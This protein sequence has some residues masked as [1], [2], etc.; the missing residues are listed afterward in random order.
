[1][2]LF[3]S[4]VIFSIKFPEETLEEIE[5]EYG[6]AEVD[7]RSIEEL[8]QRISE[9][10]VYTP[11]PEARKKIKWFI[12]YAVMVCIDFEINT[13]VRKSAHQISVSMDIGYGAFYGPVKKA[14]EKLIV[15][16]D[17][18]SLSARKDNPDSLIISIAYY[19]HERHTEKET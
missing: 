12:E 5:K 11:R 6:D 18:F 10:Y 14:L 3:D 16:A 13:E 2:E 15:F 17:D 8:L 9:K 4:E 7:M 1:M 19:T